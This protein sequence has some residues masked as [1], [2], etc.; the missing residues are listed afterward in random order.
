MLCITYEYTIMRL[1]YLIAL[2]FVLLPGSLFAQPKLVLQPFA[3][4]FIGPLGVAHAEDGR[5]FIVQQ[6]GLIRIVDSTG[7]VLPQ[8]FLDLRNKVSQ[9]GSEKG[10][11][12]LAFHPNYAQ[13]GY[14]YVNY[15][16]EGGGAG[17]TTVV[18][19]FSMVPGTPNRADSLSE[20]VLLTVPQPY[21][22]HNGGW[23]AFGPDGYLY[24]GMG[25]GGSGGDPQ[26]YAQN[27]NS[28]LGK[29][30]RIDVD[31]GSPYGIP[32]DNPFV[33][34]PIT[35][36]EIWALGVRNPWRCSF[37]KL[38][39][40][41]WIADVGQS[42]R[43]EVN[44]QAAASPGG[45]NYGWRCYEGNV[46]YNLNGCGPS[47]NYVFPVFEYAHY[48]SG[49][50][51]SIT[52]GY[53]Y[54]GALY[55]GLYGKYLAADYCKGNIYWVEQRDTGIASGLVGQYSPFQ[56]SAFGEDRYGE[57]YLTTLG[58]GSVLRVIDTSDCRPVAMVLAP[59]TLALCEGDSIGLEAL[60]HP[61][62]QYQWLL[63]G[64]E[65]TGAQ[66]HLL[67]ADSS[68]SYAVIVTNPS[69][70]CSDTSNN[71]VLLVVPK[72]QVS[73]SGL[74]SVYG[75]LDP[76]VTMTGTPAGGTFSGPGVIGNTFN[77]MAVWAGLYDITYTF[78]SAEG[79]TV[80]V[81]Q[82]VVVKII[83]GVGAPEDGMLRVYPNPAQHGFLV[84]LANDKPGHGQAA[85]FN[86]TG[87]QVYQSTISAGT[88]LAVSTAGFPKGVY[89]LRVEMEGYWFVRQVVV[90]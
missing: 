78:I 4:G 65:I 85:L 50:N 31:S 69:T 27:R 67:T 8:P 49:C 88:A 54:R 75:H 37:D 90:Q 60:Y 35:L 79:C 5:L 21:S 61:K 22:N 55:K 68:G 7:A 26:N 20:V 40:D 86:S 16:R 80:S 38:T 72:P 15:T 82:Q 12:G 81:T 71:V 41:L 19:R 25:D 2:L 13:N 87:Q 44:L 34:D 42:A 64:M 70:S 57:L 30:L 56:Y 18:S 52:G 51:G 36:N 11:L 9:S 14:F 17:G 1:L 83:G 28:M 6:R 59:D 3:T 76:P 74:D 53:V 29:M 46:P 47:S 63:D 89:V 66:G 58:S 62:L 48:G 10:L 73:I 45:E 32:A 43:E 23:I 84:D 39:G 77:P 24:I 33:G